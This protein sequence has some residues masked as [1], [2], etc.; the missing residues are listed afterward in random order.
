MQVI[1]DTRTGRIN[2]TRDGRP[3]LRGAVARAMTASG[4]FATSDFRYTR[5]VEAR[6]VRH[7][8]GAGREM[9]MRCADRERRLD[10]EV[11]ATLVTG[12]DAL[13]VEAFYKNISPD[14]P[15]TLPQAE[16]VRAVAD[17]GGACL[18][19][20]TSRA[21]T[22]GKMYYNAGHVIDLEKDGKA[23]G[24][25]NIGLFRGERAPG[26]TIGYIRNDE[27]MGE[28]S[29]A[30]AAGDALSVVAASSYQTQFTLKPGETVSSS[31]VLFQFAPDPF[32]ALEDYAQAMG[33][34]HHVR[35]N[36]VPNG[37]CTWTY[38]Y[39]AI[40]E[41]EI[42][43]NA[44][45]AAKH[46]KPYGFD[47]MQIDD[48]YYRAQGDWEGNDRFPHG[49]KWMAQKIRE[50]GLTPG[51]WFA[52]FAINQG[53]DVYQNHPDWLLRNP[54]GSIQ[55][56]GPQIAEGSKEAHQPNPGT[57][58]LDITHPGAADWLHRLFRTAAEDWGYDFIKIDF[59]D[60]T[61]LAAQRYH[62]PKY[63]KAAAYRE[64]V[65]IMRD[66]MGKDRHLL[67]CG[68]GPVTVGLLDSM[69]IE[70]DQPPAAWNQYFLNPPSTAPA[71]AK[72]YYFHKRTWINDADHLVTV[73]L[74]VPQAQA[75]AT[76]LGLSGGTMI[77]S[78]RLFQLE[79]DRVELIKKVFPAYGENARPVDL[80]ESDKPEVFALPIRKPFGE[81]LL[82]G[83]FN[84]DEREPAK[85]SIALDR[86]RLDPAKTYVAFDFWK[87]RFHGEVTKSLDARLNPAS[88]MLLAV[89]EKRPTPFVIS[90]DRHVTQGALEL[91][92]VTWDEAAQTLNG[93][94]LG[95]A[96][97]DHRV[98]VYMPE[99]RKYI[100]P[101]YIHQDYSGYTLRMMEPTIVRVH[102]TLGEDGRRAWQVPLKAF[103][104]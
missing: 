62:D 24:W 14:T 48:G 7:P 66:A 29:V 21:L 69:R 30:K 49:M 71:M 83:L 61:L 80:W 42:I 27:G 16:P 40:N 96:N 50:F 101:P 92:S 45:F 20:G 17:D 81:W 25:W 53:T 32:T 1:F 75:A 90:T 84:A 60:W 91:E 65:R 57:A 26:L 35:L 102:V 38:A 99:G 33:D 56:C 97:T 28:M 93:I 68:P 6:D 46:L 12:R 31:P 5:T 9:T 76:L 87:G 37:W 79:P 55:A 41:D 72:R 88:G 34:M 10:I 3:F 98:F 95:P 77:V 44:E 15:V 18:W 36:P 23:A 47:V 63:T 11:R 51:I 4:D 94:S 70:L 43:R 78:D 67:D 58:G 2:V 100:D 59:V 74:T 86:L 89:H 104:A 22:N 103:I 8:L 52:P 82:V 13:I 64:G 39:G 85:K 19:P 54:D 73:N